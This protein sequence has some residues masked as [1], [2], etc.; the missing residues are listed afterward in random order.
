MSVSQVVFRGTARFREVKVRLP[1]ENS[2][3]IYKMIIYL[4]LL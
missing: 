4:L 3:T 1:Q 2:I